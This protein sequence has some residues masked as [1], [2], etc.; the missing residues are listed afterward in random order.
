MTTFFLDPGYTCPITKPW[1]K[2]FFYCEYFWDPKFDIWI[3]FTVL[4]RKWEFNMMLLLCYDFSTQR[5]PSQLLR[6]KSAEN[7]LSVYFQSILIWHSWKSNP[8]LLL[9]REMAW[10]GRPQ[11]KLFC[12]FFKVYDFGAEGFIASLCSCLFCKIFCSHCLKKV[13]VLFIYL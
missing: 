11:K 10:T 9:F 7:F 3:L 4:C 8:V 1:V 6:H 13:F 12:I 2:R 5:M